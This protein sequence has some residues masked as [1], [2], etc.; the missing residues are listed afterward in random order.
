MVFECGCKILGDLG[1][2]GEGGSSY[3]AFVGGEVILQGFLCWCVRVKAKDVAEKVESSFSEF[4]A[5]GSFFAE[6]VEVLFADFLGVDVVE[7]DPK[8]FSLKCI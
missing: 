2:P 6:L 1:Q 5:D 7:C 8:E 3:W 4:F